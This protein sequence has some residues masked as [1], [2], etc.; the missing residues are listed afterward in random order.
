MGYEYA[1]VHLKYTIPPAIFLSALYYPLCTR[2]DLYKIAFL[3]TVAVVSTI[4]WDSYLIRH[5]VWSY[6]P[7]VIIGPTL[8]DIP[9]EE[10]FFFVIQTFNTTLLYLIAS[11]PVLKETY[12]LREGKDREGKKWKYIKLG[13][14]LVMALAL[15]QGIGFLKDQ[16]KNTYLGLILVWALPFL[17]LLWSLAYQFIVRLPIAC[18]ALPIALPTLYLWVVD[19]L[20]LKRGTWVIESGTKTGLTLWPG[21]EIEEALFFL[22]T[23]CLIVFGLLAFDNAVAILNAFPAHFRIVPSLPSPVMLVQALLLPASTYDDDRILGLQQAVSRL[24]KK[25]RSFFLASSTF[26]GRLRIDLIILYSFCRVADDLIDN[27]ES[28]AEARKWVQ[29]LKQYLDLSYGAAQQSK[30][31]IVIGAKDANRGAATLFTV[32]NFPPE[33]QLALLMLPTHRL[34]KEPLYELLKGFEMDLIFSEK[35]GNA[36]GPIKSEEVLDQY[37]ARVAGTVALLCIQ[38]V[39]HHYPETSEI[40]AKKLM[41]AG[42][43]MGIALQYTNIARDLGVDAAINRCYVPPGWLKKEKLTPESFTAGLVK[44]ESPSEKEPDDFFLK[45]VETIRTRLL[46][47]AFDFYEGSIG[48]VEELPKPARAPMRVAVE[49]YMQIGRELRTPGFQVKAGRATVPK[50][51]R[52]AVAW[53]A[54]MGPRAKA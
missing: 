17:L 10:V 1:V 8:F 31:G 39:I 7:N 47:R 18:T 19:T 25:S 9:L 49:S 53:T 29:K 37:G 14:Q 45:K 6:P 26:Q 42:H 33:T 44:L 28:P 43:N 38:L 27:A 2:L 13:G 50:W 4:P 40:K 48:A 21:L 51:K 41:L 3:I 12:L 32:H 36:T 54:L 24:E 35:K 15:K 20:A 22:L 46:D 5:N 34:D 52:I 11:K 30:D 23:N 16:S